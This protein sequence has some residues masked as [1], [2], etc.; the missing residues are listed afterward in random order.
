LQTRA[1]RPSL[2]SLDEG[3]T[4]RLATPSRTLLCNYLFDQHRPLD[5]PVV[6][7]SGKH[8]R[9]ACCPP[10]SVGL[11]AFQAS[12][13]PYPH[14]A[15]QRTGLTGHKSPT[16]T[17]LAGRPLDHRRRAAHAPPDRIHVPRKCGSGSRSMLA[18]QKALPVGDG[19]LDDHVSPGS[20][21][22]VVVACGTLPATDVLAIE[23]V[24]EMFRTNRPACGMPRRQQPVRTGAL[25]SD[26]V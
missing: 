21:V 9:R 20:M 19:S 8:Y 5:F 17:Q 7:Q 3:I 23:M 2:K 22:R 11:N 6:N 15:F 16:G 26:F 10:A 12:R 25:P 13:S 14:R 4:S 18:G 1:P 24:V